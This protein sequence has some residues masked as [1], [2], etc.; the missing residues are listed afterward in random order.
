MILFIKLY[1][2]RASNILIYTFPVNICISDRY[3]ELFLESYIIIT[4]YL[5]RMV[6]D[7]IDRQ[8]SERKCNANISNALNLFAP[9]LYSLPLPLLVNNTY[10]YS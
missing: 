4:T 7:R 8:L 3:S 2:F 9:E 10:T 5:V 1:H 6:R